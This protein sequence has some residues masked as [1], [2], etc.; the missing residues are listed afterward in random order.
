MSESHQVA[1]TGPAYNTQPA[2]LEK[3]VDQT[4]KQLPQIPENGR[5]WL[6]DNA[7]WLALLGGVLSLWALWGAWQASQYANQIGLWAD[8]IGRAYGVPTTSSQLGVMWYV[9]LA[10]I[11]VQAVFM[12]LAFQA[13]KEHK[14]SGWNLLFYSSLVSV[15][16]G[17]AYLFVPAYGV[18]SLIGMLLGTA[19][20][21]YVLF[22]VRSHFVK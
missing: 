9:A 6:A 4:V 17:L 18:G 10:A 1:K 11:A 8:Q 22:N 2:G 20:G 16:V 12:F 7:W 13:L 15:V 14:K 3:W 21:W 19:I 5:N